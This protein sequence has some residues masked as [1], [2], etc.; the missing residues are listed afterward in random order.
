MTKAI[1]TIVAT[2]KTFDEV[3]IFLH[4][5][6]SLS[7]RTHY[8][9]GGKL[10]LASMWRLIDDVCLYSFTELRNF[11]RA[12]QAGEIPAKP[13]P[14]AE[15]SARIMAANSQNRMRKHSIRVTY[16]RRVRFTAHGEI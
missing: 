5:D 3:I 6:G 4:A 7:T 13:R 9:Y 12:A 14:T 10:P 1:P 16:D 11:L 2:R 15:E 8:L